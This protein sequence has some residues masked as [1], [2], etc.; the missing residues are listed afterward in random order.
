MSDVRQWDAALE[1]EMML[2]RGRL[3]LVILVVSLLIFLVG[4]SG[5]LEVQI[6]HVTTVVPGGGRASDATI[7]SATDIVPPVATATNLVR[8][9]NSIGTS[10]PMATPNPSSVAV[11]E[12]TE[13]VSSAT[14]TRTQSSVVSPTSTLFPSPTQGVPQV[15]SFSAEPAEAGQG[16]RIL[17]EWEAMGDRATICPLL[18]SEEVG[19]RC[20]DDLPLIGSR[21]IAPEDIVGNYSGFKLKVG[22]G[23]AD[24]E[25]WEMVASDQVLV[26][27][28][29][30]GSEEWFFE[31]AP[32]MCPKDAPLH[33]FGAAEQF[34]HG[35]MIW[36]EALDSYYIFYDQDVNVLDS[37]QVS[38]SFSSL[39]SLQIIKGPLDLKPSASRDN[40][41][42]DTPP[43]GYSQPVSGFGLVWRGEV[44]GTEQVRQ[45]LGWATEAE[46]GFDTIYL[47][48]V[49]CGP[50]Y[51]NCYLRAPEGQIL[52]LY[53]L[54]HFGHFWEE[55]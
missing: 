33:S 8:R 13:A 44:A 37:G 49:G 29:C 50:P 28:Q 34:E 12:A 4:C 46:Y 18:D 3:R 14:P 42:K 48:E 1:G 5:T 10:V 40:R 20:L 26:D 25:P 22:V 43:P 47:C 7:E 2:M 19:C 52:H 17:L 54:V 9:P 6:V 45:R 36:V 15:I 16:E 39:T 55:W 53:Y 35:L 23:D 31:N 11:E 38:P 24:I 27:V 41:V 30:P 21:V 32:Q 51:W